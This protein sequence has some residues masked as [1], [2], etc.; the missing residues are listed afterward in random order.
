MD[1]PMRKARAL[2]PPYLSQI[3]GFPT[4]ESANEEANSSPRS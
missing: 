4:N 3:A 1:K 2:L